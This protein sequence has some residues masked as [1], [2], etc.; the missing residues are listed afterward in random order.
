MC[1]PYSLSL[2]YNRSLPIG[3]HRPILEAYQGLCKTD[4]FQACESRRYHGSISTDLLQSILHLALEKKTPLLWKDG[5]MDFILVHSAYS[6]PI[7]FEYYEDAGYRNLAF[8]TMGFFL[9]KRA[10]TAS[11]IL[12]K[13]CHVQRTSAD[14]TMVRAVLLLLSA[15]FNAVNGEETD[16]ESLVNLTNEWYFYSAWS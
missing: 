7:W 6:I 3:L 4:L 9:C 13:N 8:A 12:A 1:A 11:Y 15:Q 5:R 16:G 10:S 2:L 14:D